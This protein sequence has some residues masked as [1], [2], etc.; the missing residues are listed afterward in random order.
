MFT[1]FNII[2]Y[3]TG[4]Y[5]PLSLLILITI[6]IYYYIIGYC[7]ENVFSNNYYLISLLILMLLDITSLI[8]I[9]IYDDFSGST[10]SNQYLNLNKN[11][12]KQKKH[13]K[14]KKD[15]KDH[16]NKKD[17]I[18]HKEKIDNKNDSGEQH[19]L[20][21]EDSNNDDNQN[22]KNKELISLYDK[23]YPGSIHTFIKQIN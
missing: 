2:N 11:N 10:D 19:F 17:K 16:K 6:G 18:Y 21:N 15:K 20:K 14:D 5:I 23:G 7:F 8:V 1:I 9:F 3:M 4:K 22:Y 13:K 12:K